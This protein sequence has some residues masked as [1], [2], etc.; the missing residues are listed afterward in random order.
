MYPERL[1]RLR[2]CSQYLSHEQRFSLEIHGEKLCC[3]V[4]NNTIEVYGPM[5]VSHD[6]LL[7]QLLQ[8]L[9]VFPWNKYY[10]KR[11]RK[12]TKQGLL[13]MEYLA[14]MGES[15]FRTG[16]VRIG[17]ERLNYLILYLPS[18]SSIHAKQLEDLKQYNFQKYDFIEVKIMNE[19]GKVEKF[20]NEMGSMVDY[21]SEYYGITFH[22]PEKTYVYK[23]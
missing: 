10:K 5:V 11:R 7:Y 16:N 8:K 2:I 1:L 18:K 12:N 17:G 6:E 15:I 4:E 9:Y 13:Y 3:K 19:K 20:L 22:Q 23:K 14:S 21:L